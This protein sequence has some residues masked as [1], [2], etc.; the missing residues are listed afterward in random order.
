MFT[1]HPSKGR[2]LATAAAV[3]AA[4]AA[5]LA[6]VSVPAQ[7]TTSSNG[8]TV[9][10]L[11]PVRVGTNAAGVPQVRFSTVVSCTKDRIVQIRDQR[12]EFD[13]PAGVANDQFYGSETY[14]R[15]FAVTGTVTLSTTDLVT[16]TESSDEEAYHR[17]SF[18]V[19]TINGVSAFTALEDSPRLSVAH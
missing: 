15:T 6:L 8:C 13:A 11:R 2:K 10:P 9:T 16:N 1:S 17:V 3:A 18:R 19:A 12:Y 14:L 5:P 7:A 4:V